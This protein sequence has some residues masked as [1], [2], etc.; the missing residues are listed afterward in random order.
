MGIQSQSQGSHQHCCWQS[1]CGT[2]KQN[3]FSRPTSWQVVPYLYKASQ[4]MEIWVQSLG[5]HQHRYQ[6]SLCLGTCKQ[7]FQGQHLGKLYHIH[8]QGKSKQGHHFSHCQVWKDAVLLLPHVPWGQPDL[9]MKLAAQLQLELTPS[10]KARERIHPCWACFQWW[11]CLPSMKLN[12]LL[13]SLP[14]FSSVQLPICSR[15]CVWSF[16]WLFVLSL[17]IDIYLFGHC[18]FAAA[19]C[20]F[21]ARLPGI[22]VSVLVL[23]MSWRMTPL[24]NSSPTKAH[25]LLRNRHWLKVRTWGHLEIL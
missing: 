11:E 20:W 17:L 4:S 23:H 16:S 10:L 9:A 25:K 19:D 8:V 13:P 3:L 15:L 21:K 6:Q 2:C 22:K 5:S 18:Q 14:R 12:L 7:N 1:L 24:L